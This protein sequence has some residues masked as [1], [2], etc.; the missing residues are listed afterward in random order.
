MFKS[1][2]E[3]LAKFKKKNIKKVGLSFL[4]PIFKKS[5]NQLWLVFIKILILY[6]F[7]LEYYIYIKIDVLGYAIKTTLN[8]LISDINFI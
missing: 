3:N 1:K 6:Y 5:F 8:H 2:S 7:N 4:T